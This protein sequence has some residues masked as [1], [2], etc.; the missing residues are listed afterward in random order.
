VHRLLRH[1]EARDVLPLASYHRMQEIKA[2]YGAGTHRTAC[3]HA[4]M[5]CH[6]G[7][8]PVSYCRTARSVIAPVSL[9]V[10]LTASLIRTSSPPK[11]ARIMP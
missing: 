4:C 2:T 7:S 11:L 10:F 1:T 8:V 3:M 9:G 6:R 5:P